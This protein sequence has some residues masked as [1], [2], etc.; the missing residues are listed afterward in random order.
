VVK[1]HDVVILGGGPAGISAAASLAEMGI[2]DIVLIEREAALGGVPRHCGHLAFGL[3]EFRRLMGGPAYARRLAQTVAGLDVRTHT[4]VS[5]IAPG[6]EVDLLH[7][8]RG[9]EKVS[10]RAVLL[11][12]GVRETPR[13]T[14]LVD[15]DRPWGVTTTGA[16]QQFV[17][18]AGIR[19][20]RRAVV[21]GSELVAFSA[22]LTLRHGGMSAAAMIEAGPR[23][24]ARRPGD[25]VARLLLGVPVLTETSLVAIQG[26]GKVEAVEIERRGRRQT[27]A[28]DGV[29]FTGGF[30]P[31]TAILAQSHIALDPGTR[32]PAIDQYWR[33]SDPQFFVA[34]NLLRP[35]ETAGVAWAEGRAV[36][37]SIAAEL[38]GRL[39]PPAP[40]TPLSV[41]GLL[42]YAYPQRLILPP[43][44]VS[45][46]LLKARMTRA[47]RGRL[48]LT[49][50]GKELWGRRM[51]AL[52]E[53][54]L[55]LPVSLLP[56]GAAGSLAIDFQEE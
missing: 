32:G 50:D 45:P 2:R 40:A 41:G 11:A 17:Y 51:S 53:R 30:R 5:A 38:A 49:A 15:G 10:G 14:R 31:E 39:P 52:P 13:S 3:R 47:A 56:Q 19:P 26:N 42:K 36:G 28:C 34:G 29:I 55:S 48:R 27:I 6:G 35:V 4:T 25:W 24:T 21:V 46:L 22:L 33:A 44:N 20:F 54:R 9:P 37:K 8:E 7:P 16:L 23:I 18:I 1:R 12:F 43:G